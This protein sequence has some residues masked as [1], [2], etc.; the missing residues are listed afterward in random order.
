[1]IEKRVSGRSMRSLKVPLPFF[2][3][4]LLLVAWL[5]FPLG[6]NRPWSW[7]LF[8]VSTFLLTASWLIWLAVRKST[9]PRLVR[10]YRLP[11]LLMF[12]WI[13]YQWLQLVPVPASFLEWISPPTAEIYR[14]AEPFAPDR[15]VTLSLDRGSTLEGIFKNS[16]YVF[17]F[18]LTLAFVTSGKRLYALMIVLLLVGV[19]QSVYG[20]VAYLA[21]DWLGLWKPVAD[22]HYVANGTFPNK[23][24][25]GAHVV[26]AASVTLGLL[27]ASMRHFESEKGGLKVIISRWVQ[28]MLEPRAILI[29]ALFVLFTALFFSASRGASLSLFVALVAVITIGVSHRGR[30]SRDAALLPIVALL[31]VGAAVI[32]GT[33]DLFLRLLNMSVEGNQRLLVWSDVIEMIKDYPL[34]GIGEGGFQWLYPAYKGSGVVE[35]YY[36]HV[37]NDYL[38]ILVD[39]GLI[40][41]LLIGTAILLSLLSVLRGYHHRN[42]SLLRG[43][44]FAS[45]TA[46][47][48]FLIHALFDFNFKIPANAAWFFVILAM[49]MVS[50]KIAREDY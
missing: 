13:G 15:W 35:N 30:Y 8:E 19:I 31:F 43:A 27:L 29:M 7:S 3:A 48:A 25:F 6:S 36:H 42:A 32:M 5:P 9:F 18:I 37:H 28:L 40:G 47:L 12:G 45:L 20:I 33:N 41:S 44:C 22:G 2:M 39:Q 4:L 26:M 34:L 1:M 38:E 16:A 10:E 17:L 14:H 21:D 46:C 24:H 23:N 11:I 49:G 50:A